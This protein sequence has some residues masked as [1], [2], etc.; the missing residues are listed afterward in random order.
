MRAALTRHCLA[1]ALGLLLAQTGRAQTAEVAPLAATE[2]DMLL[3]EVRVDQQPVSDG[4][5]AYQ[6]ELDV[7]LPLGELARLLTLAITT[8][9]EKGTASGFILDE[10]RAF[11]LDLNRATVRLNGKSEAVDLKQIEV[12]PDDIYVS[13]QLLSRWLPVDLQVDMSRLTLQVRA[14]ESLPLQFRLAREL[15]GTQIGS[16]T[17]AA[18]RTYPRRALPYR[19]LSTPFVDQTVSVD[20]RGGNGSEHLEGRYTAYATADVLGMQGALHVNAGT[21]TATD[22]QLTLGRNDPDAGLLGPMRARTA[23]I[24]S[25]A[26]PAVANISRTS[27]LGEGVLVSN[28]PLSQPT[29]FG[30]HSLRGPLPPGWDVE[31]Y[32]NDVLLGFQASRPDGQYH[33]DDQPLV[34]GANEFRLVFHGP[35]GQL[36]VERQ[37]FLLE[38]SMTPAGKLYYSVVLQRDDQGRTRTVVEFDR[39]ISEHITVTGGVVRAV[40]ADKAQSFAHVGLHTYWRAMLLSGEW[41]KSKDGSLA[42]VSVRTRL[43]KWAVSASHAQLNNFA[44]ELY[45]PSG[46]PVRTSSRARVDGAVALPGTSLRLP[47]TVEASREQRQSG[48]SNVDVAGRMSAHLRGTSMTGQIHWQSLAGEELA[49]GTFQ[50]SRRVG[51]VSVRGQLSYALLPVRELTAVTL[52]ADKRWGQGYLQTM[53]VT[54]LFGSS[55]TL[56]TAGL[57][58]SLGNFGLGI[59]VGYSTSGAITAGLQLFMGLGQEPRTSD[60][61]FD[62][63]PMANDGGVSA[64]VFLDENSNGRMDVGEQPIPGVAFTVNGGKQPVTTDA[65]GVAYLARLPVMQH[66]DVAVVPETLEDPQ[67]LP[68][69]KGLRVVPRPGAVATL[70]FPVVMTSE[71]DGTVYLVENAQ[72]REIGALMIEVIDH[73]GAAIATTI[74]AADGYYLLIGVPPGDYVVQVSPSQLQRLKL[75]DATPHPVTVAR[76]GQPVTGVDIEVQ[77]RP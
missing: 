22:V 24:G 57:T 75:H 21:A 68:R 42:E 39:G 26:V 6:S 19:L 1:V 58:K 13:A 52:S 46:D 44:S 62:A 74:S 55:E 49:D 5:T 64:L 12:R 15:K 47:V 48:A 35:L 76:D 43:G 70:D 37:T 30:Q 63:Q 50:M 72:R 17:A 14:R 36:R 18:A 51:G 28:R 45:Q 10:D 2:P 65:G 66:T 20:Y 3:L 41:V 71:V 31:L 56:Y 16:R 73:A 77:A 67:W 54:R 60:W 9:P 34:F 11:G 33:F 27:A 59:N 38:S 29:S 53:S 69:V 4:L 61:L 8:Q 23:L 7:L 25:L 32:F 40:A